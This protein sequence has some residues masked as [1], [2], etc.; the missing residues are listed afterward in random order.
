MGDFYQ[1]VVLAEHPEELEKR[2]ELPNFFLNSSEQISQIR[3]IDPHPTEKVYGVYGSRKFLNETYGRVFPVEEFLKDQWPILLDLTNPRSESVMEPSW[4]Q[5]T[6]II[7]AFRQIG[8]D[9]MADQIKARM[10][11]KIYPQKVAV[12][13]AT[14]PEIYNVLTP[15]QRDY[16]MI[17]LVDDLPIELKKTIGEFLE[18]AILT[19]CTDVQTRILETTLAIL[20]YQ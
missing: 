7:R 4:I 14:L 2:W 10:L 16:P 20:R 9:S 5:Q 18:E 12:M 11:S 6:L 17:L 13:P 15:E 19:G 8:D 3:T 1:E